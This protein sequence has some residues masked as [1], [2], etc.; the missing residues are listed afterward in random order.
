MAK[1]GKISIVIKAVYRSTSGQKAE[2]CEGL[3][4]FLYIVCGGIMNYEIVIE[5]N[6]KIVI[7]GGFNIDCYRVYYITSLV[8]LKKGSE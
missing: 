2:F 3:N 6:Y 7:V 4:E 8:R 1:Y 5:W